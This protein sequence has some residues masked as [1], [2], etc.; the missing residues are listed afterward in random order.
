MTTLDPVSLDDPP[1]LLTPFTP[2]PLPA[3]TTL[4]PFVPL[5]LKKPPRTAYVQNLANHKRNTNHQCSWCHSQKD[6]PLGVCDKCMRSLRRLYVSREWKT[7]RKEILDAGG[8]CQHCRT[9]IGEEVHHIKEWFFFPSLFFEPTN[10]LLLCMKC[11]QQHYTRVE[12]AL[13]RTR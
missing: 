6:P 4:T 5:K 3:S 10:L 1:P 7:L 9:A 13:W 12:T 2:T 11:H 8:V